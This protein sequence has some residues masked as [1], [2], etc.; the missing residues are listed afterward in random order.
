MHFLYVY[1]LQFDIKSLPRL[2]KETLHSFRKE[3]PAKAAR[4]ARPVPTYAVWEEQGPDGLGPD[5]VSAT[6]ND[7]WAAVDERTMDASTFAKM[8]R[9]SINVA[10]APPPFVAPSRPTAA[11]RGKRRCVLSDAR[12]RVDIDFR[13]VGKL[14]EFVSDGGKIQGRKKTGLTAKAQRKMSRAVK[15]ARTMAL[16]APDPPAGLTLK[17]MQEMESELK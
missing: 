1:S 16:I 4:T 14:V 8:R 9:Q 3:L 15:C 5:L 7:E 12:G 11:S 13:S 17:E 2:P 6:G 10:D